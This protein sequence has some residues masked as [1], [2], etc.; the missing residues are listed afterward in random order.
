M[1]VVDEAL[2]LK[3]RHRNTWRNRSNLFWLIG[4]LEEVGELTLSLIGLHKHPP[5]LELKQIAT[6]ALNWLEKR[7]WGGGTENII[8]VR[9]IQCT[10]GNWDA[11]EYMRGMSNGLIL[12][13]SIMKDEDP[14]YKQEVKMYDNSIYMEIRWR[15]YNL[16]FRLFGK[17]KCWPLVA[18]ITWG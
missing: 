12:A 10:D 13:T 16:A 14:E 15:V 11:D 9:D 4:L 7:E 3:E 6:I 8:N 18:K 17:T 5:D 2:K 1:T